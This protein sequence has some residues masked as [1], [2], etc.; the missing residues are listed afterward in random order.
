MYI[1]RHSSGSVSDLERA[2]R[3]RTAESGDFWS[4]LPATLT[5]AA[6]ARALGINE[7]TTLRRL[8]DGRLPGYR[9]TS[10]SWL[11][12][13]DEVRAHLEASS[14]R[15]PH[16]VSTPDVLDEYPDVLGYRD[17]MR[18]LGKSKPTVYSWLQS[19]TIPAYFLDGRWLVY[20]HELRVALDEVRNCPREAPA[21]QLTN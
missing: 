19:G 10:A 11:V 9:L 7:D 8:R 12:F 20:R 21:R 15:A 18:V 16:G 17:L 14:N 13:R 5:T 3:R 6:L 4:D 2:R 1:T